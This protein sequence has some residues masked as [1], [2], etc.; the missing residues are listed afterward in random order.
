MSNIYRLREGNVFTCVHRITSNYLSACPR[1]GYHGTMSFLG[2]SLV[3]GPFL[4]EVSMSRGEWVCPE[5]RWVCPGG[6]S[7]LPPD[8]RYKVD[9]VGKQ[10]VRVI[11]ECFFVFDMSSSAMRT[12]V[13]LWSLS[14]VP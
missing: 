3:P 11:L 13:S 14:F 1:G 7:P 8:M 2:V 4:G 6:Y 9:T 5:W 12:V 10:A